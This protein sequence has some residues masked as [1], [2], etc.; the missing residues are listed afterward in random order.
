MTFWIAERLFHGIPDRSPEFR[1][2]FVRAY[3]NNCVAA[4][5]PHWNA[6]FRRVLFRLT[7]VRLGRGGFIGM[8]GYM[9]DYRPENILIE[10][11]VTI[12]FG[13]TFIAHGQRTGKNDTEKTII[14][15]E[16]AYVGA[17]AVLLPG[18]EIGSCAVIG[19]GAVVTKD[20]AP[21]AVVAGSPAK[22]LPSS[23]EKKQANE[24]L[25]NSKV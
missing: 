14:I 1:C 22:V 18:I 13:V 15:R 16:G 8:G 19:A 23:N 9:E 6:P 25:A 11:N 2:Q 17:A 7:G 3:I 12:S 4:Q 24:Y 21:G 20:V 10:N 5:L